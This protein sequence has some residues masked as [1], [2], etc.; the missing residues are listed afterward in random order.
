MVPQI[1]EAAD[2]FIRRQL[3]HNFVHHGLHI[4]FQVAVNLLAGGAG[5]PFTEAHQQLF[6]S[7]I[8][9]DAAVDLLHDFSCGSPPLLPELVTI[10]GLPFVGMEQILGEDFLAEYGADLFNS[11]LAQMPFPRH[12]GVGNEVDMGMMGF[13][14]ESG[15]PP[16]MIHG[17]LQLIR[18]SLG[19]APQKIPPAAPVIEA[20]PCRILPPQG[21]DGSVDMTGI[22]LQFLGYLTQLY[23]HPCIGKQ[24]VTAEPFRPGTGGNVVGIGFDV[25]GTIQVFFQGT[26]DQLRGISHRLFPAVILV[27]REGFGVR[28]IP[29]HFLDQLLLLYRCQGMAF[30]IIHLFHPFTGGNVLGVT[31]HGS[32]AGAGLHVLE[33]GD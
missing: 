10:P 11:M 29:Q 30:G 4:R 12:G 8:G 25:C 7:G 19:L 18:E 21:E 28:K 3:C 5:Q 32:A 6:H 31:A 16:Q 20:Q 15:I 2:P 23:L 1:I 13:I 9:I 24:A 17:D 33:F 14:M 27:F 26:G 22:V